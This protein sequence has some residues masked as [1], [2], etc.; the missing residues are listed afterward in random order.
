MC[1]VLLFDSFRGKKHKSR[2]CNASHG[3][4]ADQFADA[5]VN[6]MP[7]SF[8]MSHHYKHSCIHILARLPTQLDPGTPQ[9]ILE[10]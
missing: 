3:E 8:V 1:N 2:R 4:S 10:A 7:R 9:V 6:A 5:S